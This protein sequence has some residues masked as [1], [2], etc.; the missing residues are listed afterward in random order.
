MRLLAVLLL[1]ANALFFVWRFNA[2]LEDDLAARRRAPPLP[3][4]SPTLSLVRELPELPPARE[5]PAELAPV[6]IAQAPVATTAEAEATEAPAD[7]GATTPDTETPAEAVTTPGTDAPV[8]VAGTDAATPSSSSETP[9]PAPDSTPAQTPAQTDAA[10][11][12]PAI[13]AAM[14]VPAD[15]AAALAP[16]PVT[17]GA[18][19]PS[20]VCV[21]VGP[22][23]LDTDAAPLKTWLARR[24]SRLTVKLEGN[25][26]RPLFGI[27]LEPRTA[28]EK[29][30]DLRDLAQRGV[31]D[32]LPVRRAGVEHA[33]SLGVFSSQ[34]NVN[35]RLAEIEKQGYRPIV[36]PRRDAGGQRFV[37]AEL[38][39]GF[40]DPANIPA[41]LLGSAS[42][43][44]V[45]CPP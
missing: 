18:P 36:V 45:A 35:R 33:I 25:T 30:R 14:P 21:K 4:Q 9:P 15:A 7:V 11:P 43:K 6:Q 34:E 20:G 41:E 27:Y 16:A 3:P 31:R 13:A 22:F 42:A 44:P 8:V 5:A 23:A 17:P 19:V 37:E 2:Q 32:Y 26:Q 10:T 38:A 29:E 40:E 12:A 28:E 39:I 24:S 1:V